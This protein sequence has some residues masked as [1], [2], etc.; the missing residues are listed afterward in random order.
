[1]KVSQAMSDD[2]ETVRPEATLKEAA[3]KMADLDLGFLPV[4]D[5]ERLV[6]MITDRDIAVRA[7]AQGKDP[8]KTKVKDVISGRVLYCYD[9]ADVEEAANDMAR[10]Q[11]RRMPIVDRDKRLV[12]V[13]SLA[14]IAIKHD[15]ERAGLALEAVVQPNG[16]GAIAH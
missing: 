9:D 4:G 13:L 5:D 7:V 1:M 15:C 10:L 11:I 2:V 16:A 3:K 6:G 14:D 12:G 8:A